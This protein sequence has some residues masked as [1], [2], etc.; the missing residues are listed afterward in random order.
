MNEI[1]R[2]V[3][4]PERITAALD[5]IGKRTARRWYALDGDLPL[6]SVREMRDALLDHVAA[7][8]MT[9]AAFLTAQTRTVLRTAAEFTFGYLELG[10]FPGGDFELLCPLFNTKVTSDDLRF[11]EYINF[12]SSVDEAPTA[13]SWVDAFALCLISGTVRE[14]KRAIGL[15]LRGDLA[16][17]IR[18]GVP[19]SRLESRSEPAD[20]AQMDALCSYLTEAT[21]HLPRDWPTVV[22]RKPSAEELAEAARGLDE[23]RMLSPDQRLLRIL[24]DDDQPAFER[25][26]TDHLSE[27][28]KNVPADAAP[29]TLLPLHAIAVAALAVQVHGWEL[30]VRSDYLPSQLLNAADG[31]PGL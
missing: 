5:D 28:R 19:Y 2:H 14:W 20:L 13:Q 8:S 25:A 30:T 18:A 9:D 4:D 6:A 12:E 3:V 23:H 27:Y 31:A 1:A 11:D 10:V 15:M 29:R 24:L 7:Q 26:V 16:H 21:G 17:E 22:L